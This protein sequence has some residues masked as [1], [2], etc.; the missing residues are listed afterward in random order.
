MTERSSN[1]SNLETGTSRNQEIT[2]DSVDKQISNE[3]EISPGLRS[4]K[5]P[6]YH[7]SRK[8][9]PQGSQDIEYF[10][11]MAEQLFKSKTIVGCGDLTAS[12]EYPE[13]FPIMQEEEKR[14]LVDRQIYQDIGNS[15]NQKLR[16]SLQKTVAADNILK[17]QKFND[18][19]HTAE[20]SGDRQNGTDAL[21]AVDGSCQYF[22]HKASLTSRHMLPLPALKDKSKPREQSVASQLNRLGVDF[23]RISIS[24]DEIGGVPWQDLLDAS[25]CI[26]EALAIREKYAEFAN[27]KVYLTT[28]KYIQKMNGKDSLLESFNTHQPTVSEDAPYHPPVEHRCP[29]TDFSP[30][31]FPADSEMKI[32]MVNGVFRVYKDEHHKENDQPL[33][34]P[35]PALAPFILDLNRIMAMTVDGLLKNFC[36]RR[37][38]YLSS[39]FQLHVLLNETK[40]LA[41]QKEV[42]HRDFYNCRK[43]DTH[44]HASA[45]MNQKHLLRFMKKTIKMQSPDIVYSKDGKDFTLQ[46][47][48]QDLN[49]S[50]YDLS[51]DS[52]D[53]HADRNLFHRFDKYNSK[54]NPIGQSIL[55]EIYIETD[56]RAG[57]KFFAH[58][59]KEVM[60]DLE[61]SKYQQSE[62]RLSIYGRSCDEW[63]KLAKWAV[64]HKVY[65]DNVRWLIQIPR[66]FDIYRSKGAL[67]NFSDFLAN[68]FQPLFEATLYPSKHPD[69]YLF[70]QHVTG[71]DSVDDESK[72]EHHVFTMQSPL[73]EKWGDY[74]NP[75]YSYYVYY[76]YANMVTLNQLRK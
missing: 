61:E 15:S 31:D 43:V 9:S 60:D 63:E 22:P 32:K 42:P 33:D 76:M 27:H 28:A 70:L 34:L 16:K 53:L 7:R 44:I 23:H 66:L 65:S 74:G 12:C 49:L 69:I 21:L 50:A 19:P 72:A 5:I 73:P 20:E 14:R 51:F 45:C 25:E 24:S 67:S 56:N 47:V 36:Y 41:A 75:P 71:F 13:E 29:Y 40:E 26:A 18:R 54:Y 17:Q 6:H 37:L 57:G 30:E 58:V 1:E 2:S 59:I 48:F 62:L 10:N 52:L 64:T 8:R 11:K 46:E 68:V 3:S 35:Y 4:P 55:R 39:K 38:S